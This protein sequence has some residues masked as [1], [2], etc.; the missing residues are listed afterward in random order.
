MNA[1]FLRLH[2]LQ[3]NDR[4]CE[5]S[6]PDTAKVSPQDAPALNS[7]ILA[8]GVGSIRIHNDQVG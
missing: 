3:W 6:A 1:P 2:K 4:Q 8:L 5:H 7:H